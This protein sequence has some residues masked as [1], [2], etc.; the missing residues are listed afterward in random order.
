MPE[1]PSEFMEA[2][3]SACALARDPTL[4]NH[5][6]DNERE[7][8]LQKYVADSI[9]RCVG[10]LISRE[11]IHSAEKTA[12]TIAQQVAPLISSDKQRKQISR[13]IRNSK[14]GS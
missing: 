4:F 1:Q 8:A 7:V 10:P 14:G 9:A 6:E 13:V 11:R 3:R 2:S 5:L 12:A